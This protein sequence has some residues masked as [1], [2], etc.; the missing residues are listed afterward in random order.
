VAA[1]RVVKIADGAGVYAPPPT[2]GGS[3]PIDPAVPDTIG[4]PAAE[5]V[6][7]DWKE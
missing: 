6:S 2:V 3:A 7:R 1:V 4:G 5:A